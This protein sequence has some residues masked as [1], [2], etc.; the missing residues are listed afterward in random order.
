M[1]FLDLTLDRYGALADRRII[2]RPDALVHVVVGPNEA[3]KSTT[4][5]AIG[6][7]LFG[8]PHKTKQA[9]EHPPHA[10]A[11]SATLR[12]RAGAE[13]RLTRRKTKPLLTDGAGAEIFPDALLSFT[14]SL[15]RPLFERAFGLDQKRLELAGDELKE[16]KGDLAAALFAAASGLR[17]LNDLK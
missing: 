11:V 2:F 12:N 15:T 3:G 10:L 13:L 4:L 17:G 14:G 6:D 5:E 16:S 7:L 1:R 9:F 8:F